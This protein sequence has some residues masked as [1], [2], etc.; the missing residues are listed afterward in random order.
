[1]LNARKR[2]S[3]LVFLIPLLAVG[4]GLLHTATAAAA[5]AVVE[6]SETFFG[7]NTLRYIADPG[8]TNTV[9]MTPAAPEVEI[10]DAGATITAGAGCTSLDPNT[11]RCEHEIGWIEVLLGDGDDVLTLSR[12]RLEGAVFR[13]QDGNDTLVTGGGSGSLERLFG[14]PGND[15]LRGRRGSDFLNGG[16]GADI[17][18]G[19][20]SVDY[21]GLRIFTPSIDTVTYEGRTSDVFADP[22]GVADDGEAGEGDMLEDDVEQLVGGSGNDVL[23]GITAEGRIG[24]EKRLFGSQLYG[25]RGNDILRGARAGDLLIGGRGQDDLRGNRGQDRVKG[26]RGNDRLVGGAGRDAIGGGDGRDLLL[27]RDGR[28]DGV[29]GGSGNDSARIDVDLDR[30]RRVET[31]L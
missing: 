29:N 18:S 8:E 11:V 27:A 19:G 26:G 28:A 2:A 22:D 21:G 5:T 17:L 30:L 25:R 10:T 24:G 6:P 13:G 23:V 16:P 9:T 4:I 7:Q 15:T 12:V 14:G 31:I 3:G 20:T 1:M